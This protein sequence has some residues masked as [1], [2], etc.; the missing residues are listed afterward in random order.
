MAGNYL[1]I[2]HYWRQRLFASIT[3]G[4]N[5]L[6]EIET[7]LTNVHGYRYNIQINGMAGVFSAFLVAFKHLIPE[8]R[9]ALLGSLITIRVKVKSI[10]S[11][12]MARLPTNL[13]LTEFDRCRNSGK[14]CHV[15]ALPSHRIL[16][17]GQHRLG[18]RLDL[19][20]VLQVPGWY[21]G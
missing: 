6:D 7:V 14:H 18:N 15:G 16:Q 5:R 3:T 13:A 9:V 20:P 10:S 1:D 21:S 8:H 4:Q 2:L 12:V 17:L 11:I 19:Y